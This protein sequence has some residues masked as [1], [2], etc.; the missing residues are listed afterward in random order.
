MGVCL[1][2]LVGHAPRTH[3]GIKFFPD[4]PNVLAFAAQEARFVRIAIV[5][6]SGSQ[7]CID[8]LEVYG[9]PSDEN[10]ALASRGSKAT[11]SSCIAGYSIHRIEHLNDGRYGNRRSWIAAGHADEWAQVELARVER[12]AQVVFSRDREGSFRDRLPRIVEVQ[13]SLDGQRWQTVCRVE[14]ELPPAAHN[15]RDVPLAK[16]PNPFTWDAIL[17]YA[18]LCERDTWRRMNATDHLSPLRTERPALP[19]GAPY[20]SQ[21][22][23]RDALDRVLTQMEEMGQRLAAKG[24]DVTSEQRAVVEFRRRTAKLSRAADDPRSEALLLDVRMA[25]RELMLRDPDLAPLQRILFAK[26]HPYLA[27]HNYSDVLDSQF[28]PGGGICVLEIP[29]RGDRLDPAAAHVSTLFD[30][31]N[32][33]AR[34]PIT[35]FRAEKVYFAYRPNASKSPEAASYWHLWEMNVDGSAPRRLTDGPFHDYFPCPLPDR[36][37][38]FITTRCRSRFLCWRPQAFVLFRIGPDSDTPVPLSFANLSEWTPAVMRDGRVLWT[39]SEYVDKGANFGHTLWAIHPDG[40]H[41]ELIFGN[42]TNNCYMNAH[43]VPGTNELCCTLVSHG[44]DHNGPIGLIDLSKAPFDP[45]A[46]TNITPDIAPQYDMNWLRA[47]C[48]RDPIPIARDYFLVSHAPADHFGLYVIDRYGNRELLYMDPQI[49]AMRPR[50]LQSVKSPPAMAAQERIPDSE[51]GQFTVANIYEGLPPSLSP[52]RVKYLRVCQEVRSELESLSNGEYRKDH[53][54]F[55]DFYA[56]PVHLVNG[57]NGWPSYVAKASLGLAHVE[58]D[59]S[60][61][62]YAPSGKV[63]YFQALDED[64]NEL[65]RMRSVIQLQPGERRSCVGCHEDR[66]SPAPLQRTI[67]ARRAPE[68][69]QPPPWGTEPFAYEAIVQPVWDAHC[70]RCHDASDEQ[71]INLAGT[72]D[73]QLVPASYRTLIEGAWIHYFDWGYA[74][75][76]HKAEAASFGT[77]KSRLFDLLD[78]G[79]YDVKLSR[80]EL[81]RVKCW[82]DL[83]CPLW[84]NYIYRPERLG[85]NHTTSSFIP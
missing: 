46:I 12:V 70:V 34:D 38:A 27:S 26:R 78:A 31:S 24:L 74:V 42:N 21:I 47:E 5:A 68:Q 16:L 72:H 19:G 8:E 56:T 65:Q 67:A 62:F 75:R 3:A 61:N 60:A 14:G 23:K 85:Q 1:L 43:E 30:S 63:L 54:P 51:Q 9:D 79:H 59:G 45:A 6:G 84:P 22:A 25:K 76:H 82:I 40:T 28:L 41:P 10:L 73:E 11:A 18:F 29:R 35:D 15:L 32:G 44:G 81:R 55:M 36:G 66:K 77:L 69:L 33:I 39:R 50:P 52:G 20:W 53:E 80:E 4:R 2:G 71:D 58:Q 57:P 49:G 7:P 83:N 64:F 13:L 48:F 17:R 37:I